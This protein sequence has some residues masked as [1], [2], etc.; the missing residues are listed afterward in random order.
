MAEFVLAQVLAVHKRLPEYRR[1][2]QA[3]TWTRLPQRPAGEVVVAQL[4]YGHIGRQVAGT[5]RQHGYPV[6]VWARSARESRDPQLQFFHGQDQL[7]EAV[8]PAAVV[9]SLLPHTAATQG[10]LNAAL[11]QAL[12]P[13]AFVV[14]VGRGSQ[15]VAK[16]L[17]AA[18]DRGH[19]GGACLDVQP[20]EPLPP[21]HPLWS[22]PDVIITPHIASDITVSDSVR[23][24]RE[25]VERF[26]R[27]GTAPGLV[28]PAR[29]Y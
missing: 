17:I 8:A 7:A 3:Q 29:G 1:Q 28:D 22:H 21:G 14:N 25:T 27:D 6:R 4:G 9:V 26:V 12:A 10:L 16:D 15:L 5:L 19:L 20:Q 24:V 23:R 13:G 11:F 2:Q 18:L